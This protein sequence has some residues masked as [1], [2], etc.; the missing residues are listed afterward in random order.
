MEIV[1][2]SN[3]RPKRLI[4]VRI[5]FTLFFVAGFLMFGNFIFTQKKANAQMRQEWDKTQAKITKI[6]SVGPLISQRNLFI[7]VYFTVLDYSYNWGNKNYVGKWYDT[8][9]FTAQ[10]A[11]GKVYKEGDVLDVYI[12]PHNFSNSR[13]SKLVN[14]DSLYLYT[15]L[16]AVLAVMAQFNRKTVV[17]RISTTT[18]SSGSKNNMPSGA[19]VNEELSR[20]MEKKLSELMKQYNT[21]DINDP[22]IKEE[23]N[24]FLKQSLQNINIQKLD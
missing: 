2:S 16:F 15:L 19:K 24:L 9:L 6:D 20:A 21:M 3:P 11:F 1:Q 5:L 8:S 22:R 23:M 17:S 4:V 18:F 14:L 12:D 10:H 7:P 13:A